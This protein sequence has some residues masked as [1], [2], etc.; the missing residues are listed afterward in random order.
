MP[1]G[2]GRQTNKSVRS[3]Q[4]NTETD[5]VLYSDGQAYLWLCSADIVIDSAPGPVHVTAAF[6]YCLNELS[7][8]V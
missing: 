5:A 8:I 4:L 1:V 6:P 2:D 3:L 7:Q